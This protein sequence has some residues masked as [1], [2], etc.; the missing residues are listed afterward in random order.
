MKSL[1]MTGTKNIWTCDD[2]KCGHPTIAIYRNNGVTPMFW[3]CE[4][5]GGSA[6]SEMHPEITV[7]VTPTWEWYMPDDAEMDRLS[8]AMKDHCVKGGLLPRKIA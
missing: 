2:P 4:K 8:L 6:T 3:K 5:C 7:P 1:D